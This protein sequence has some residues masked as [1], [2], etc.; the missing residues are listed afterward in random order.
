MDLLAI[1]CAI[2]ALLALA[3]AR[4]IWKGAAKL[5]G[6]TKTS[7]IILLDNSYSMDAG[8]AGT[9]NW[10]LARD[11]AARI[12]SELKNGSEASVILMGQGGGGLLDTP[13]YET[14]RLI[15]ALN[16]ADAGY[17]AATVPAAF[18]FA[19]NTFG[20][21]HESARQVI[22]LTD[23][24]RTSFPAQEDKMLTEMID[25]LK[26]QPAPPAI[27]FF[28]VGAEVKDNV[29]VES[30]DFSRLMVGVGQKVQFRANIRNFGDA[31]W[32]D[33]RVFLKVDG[34][35]KRVSQI[36]LGPHENGQVLFTHAFDTPGSHVV[37]ITA[38]AD[39]L[40]ADNTM[41]ASIPVRDKVS[42]L[43]VNGD[44]SSEPLKGETDFAEIALQPFSAAKVEN[45][46][47]IQNKVVPAEGLTAK[48][49]T[50]SAVV[51]LAN[52]RKLSDD[53][54]HALEDFV[55]TGGGL[56][57]FTGNRVDPTWWNASRCTRTARAC[58]RSRSVRWP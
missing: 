30:L 3:M 46:D 15:Q 51:V 26:K 58:F 49:L 48:A 38:D 31:K 21:M 5:L 41:L 43:L 37:E 18:D 36:N 33:L 2:P 29:A 50:E 44:P 22:M 16:K 54:L 52:V 4:P 12:V 35:D 53:Q 17:G 45:A 1:R 20:Q 19:T 24:Q 42:L 47:L 6:D 25:R 40:K 39:T 7:T 11:E 14:G 23:F 27:T 10:S 56:L 8:R 28:D 34:K 9:S 55:R 32:P 57:I 13:T